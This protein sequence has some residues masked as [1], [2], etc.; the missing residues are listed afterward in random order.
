[1]G[2]RRPRAKPTTGDLF[3]HFGLPPVRAPLPAADTALPR[4]ASPC[5][6][7]S[8]LLTTASCPICGASTEGPADAGE[9]PREP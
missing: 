3:A 2:H 9:G 7:C 1:M 6:Q 5:R 8:W 4:R